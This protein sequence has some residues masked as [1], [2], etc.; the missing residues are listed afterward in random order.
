L[1]Q[2]PSGSVLLARAGAQSFLNKVRASSVIIASSVSMA[3][4]QQGKQTRLRIAPFTFHLNEAEASLVHIATDA[5]VTNACVVTLQATQLMLVLL[6]H[7][8]LHFIE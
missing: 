6:K 1:L 8:Y 5:S 3:H 2:L 7:G 4:T